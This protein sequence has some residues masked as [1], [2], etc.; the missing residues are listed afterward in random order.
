MMKLSKVKGYE[1]RTM[2]MVKFTEEK[3]VNDIYD[4][5]LFFNPLKYFVDLHEGTGIKGQGDKYEGAN[6]IN[7][8]SVKL[9]NQDC[10]I[11]VLEGMFGKII[12]RNGISDHIPVFC[13]TTFTAD[14]FEIIDETNESYRAIFNVDK[15]TRNKIEEN[16]GNRAVVINP[17]SFIKGINQSCKDNGISYASKKVKY[18][19]IFINRRE[20]ITNYNNLTIDSLFIKD[21]YFEYQNEFRIALFDTRINKGEF[22]KMDKIKES[23]LVDIDTKDFFENYFIEVEKHI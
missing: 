22:F 12:E 4:G 10:N 16:F 8:V 9:I 5:K 23:V 21:K 6:I 11:P 18:E 17:V 19:D 15:N 20:R 14:N 1:D 13:L 7:N 3:Y 2:L